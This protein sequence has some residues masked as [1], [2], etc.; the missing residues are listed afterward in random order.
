MQHKSQWYWILCSA[1]LFPWCLPNKLHMGSD[2]A[3]NTKQWRC[4]TKEN[5]YVDILYNFNTS[6]I[7]VV[8]V[9]CLEKLHIFSF[10]C[11]KLLSIWEFNC[12]HWVGEY[13]HW[14]RASLSF[15][16]AHPHSC[17]RDLW[18]MCSNAHPAPRS[19]SMHCA[20]TAWLFHNMPVI[21]KR[22]KRGQI[23]LLLRD[24]PSNHAGS[25]LRGQHSAFWAETQ[26]WDS[27][28]R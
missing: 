12:I 17:G 13:H 24:S 11:D 21:H 3:G 2:G 28:W 26:G 6:L 15:P 18:K 9:I 10:Y 7:E 5:D 27:A 8:H 22:C 19:S 16:S 20:I 4:S 23:A 14:N 1:V 25:S